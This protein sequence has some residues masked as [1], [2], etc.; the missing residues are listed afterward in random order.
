M[1]T[2]VHLKYPLFLSSYNETCIFPTPFRTV[3]NINF[4]ENPP[5]GSQLFY[6]DGQT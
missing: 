2:R 4:Y 6:A 5:S 1:Y 3:S